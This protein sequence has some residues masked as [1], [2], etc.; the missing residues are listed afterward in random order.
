MRPERRLH[1]AIN[2][3]EAKT[4]FSE[5]IEEVG[6]SS[7]EVTLTKRGIPEAKLLPIKSAGTRQLGVARGMGW[8]APDF[9]AP[10]PEFEQ[11]M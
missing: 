5:L 3:H 11:Y 10:L 1:E 7:Q 4:H 8:V 2:I 6:G 9:D